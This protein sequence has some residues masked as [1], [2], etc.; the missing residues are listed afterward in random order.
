MKAIRAGFTLIELLIVVAIIG[1]LAV[2]LVPTISDAPAR[3]RDA[4]RKT[5]VNNVITAVES[6]NIDNG[7]YPVLSDCLRKAD[8]TVAASLI[9]E[10]MNGKDPVSTPSRPATAPPADCTTATETAVYYEG[11][12]SSYF[13]RIALEGKGTVI[14]GT[15]ANTVDP[16]YFVVTR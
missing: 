10:Y 9:N 16:G 3:A 8:N 1:I 11:T 5:M 12:A 6:Y 13:V 15:G 2:A 14:G 7:G 4:A